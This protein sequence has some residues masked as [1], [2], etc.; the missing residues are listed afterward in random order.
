MTKRIFRSIWLVAFLVFLASLALIMGMLYTYYTRVWQ[1]QLRNQ[2]TLAAQ[3]AAHEGLEY[4]EGLEI[5]DCRISW[6]GADG[7][8]LYDNRT[9]S[10]VMENH[11][12][13]EEIREALEDGMGESIRYS[14]TLQESTIYCARR[15]PDGTV[16]RF[17]T[18]QISVLTLILGMAQ[19]ICVVFA[20]A[21]VASMLLAARLSH[22]I[23]KPLNEL[24]LDE[25]LAAEHYEELNPLLHRIDAQHRQLHSQAVTLN[26]KQNEFD[27]VTA[28]MREGL[29]LLNNRCVILTINRAARKLLGLSPNS[30]GT[31]ILSCNRELG[32]LL[33]SALDGKPADK[34]MEFAGGIYRVDASPVVSEGVVSGVVLLLFDV[35]QKIHAE[36][37]RREFTANVSHELKTPLHAI[38]GYAELLQCGMVKTED[39]VPFAEKIYGEAKRMTTLVEDILHLSRLDEGMTDVAFTEVDLYQKAAE[40][41]ASLEEMAKKAQV[42]LSL[43][44][45]KTLCMGVPQLI[46]GILTNLCDNAIKYNRPQGS[47]TVSVERGEQA[48]VLTVRDTGVGIPEAHQSRIFERFYRVDKSHS[49]QLGGTGLG[50]SIVKHSVATMGGKLHLRSTPD[51]GTTI[52]VELPTERP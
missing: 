29:V 14:A 26:R 46:T 47:V 27:A 51:V 52:T 36:Q 6:I 18:A 38:S 15:L 9:D 22:S 17:S 3:A 31:D 12:Q 19:P 25:P 1:A 13:R 5:P 21:L 33:L 40:V 4:F 48:A 2:T 42:T 35:T 20:V 16:L 7:S 8:V 49:R 28:S 24:N 39:V 11:L 30:I 50:L 43:E 34:Q 37:L 44:G 41:V 32:E 10:A 45:E 23:V